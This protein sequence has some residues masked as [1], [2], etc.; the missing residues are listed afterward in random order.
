MELPHDK[1]WAYLLLTPPPLRDYFIQLPKP[2]TLQLALNRFAAYLEKQYLRDS[3]YMEKI[4]IGTHYNVRKNRVLQPRI[5][6][7]PSNYTRILSTFYDHPDLIAEVLP[8]QHLSKSQLKRGGLTKNV[9]TSGLPEMNNE[10]NPYAVFEVN[11]I[12]D[13][14]ACF[15]FPTE[16]LIDILTGRN[17]ISLHYTIDRTSIPKW[18]AHLEA[19]FQ[20]SDGVTKSLTDADLRQHYIGVQPIPVTCEELLQKMNDA[21]INGNTMYRVHGYESIVSSRM[22]TVNDLVKASGKPYDVVNVQTMSSYSRSISK[23]INQAVTK[24]RH[25]KHVGSTKLKNSQGPRTTIFVM[26]PYITVDVVCSPMTIKPGL[27]PIQTKLLKSIVDQSPRRFR[28][29]YAAKPQIEQDVL[30]KRIFSTDEGPESYFQGVELLTPEA[31]S[32]LTA[33]PQLVG[34]FHYEKLSYAH[35]P[36]YRLTAGGYN[37]DYFKRGVTVIVARKHGGKGMVAKLI[38]KLGTPVIDS[39][40]YGRIIKLVEAGLTIDDAVTQLFSMDYDQRNSTV[41][42]FDEHME[43]IVSQSKMKQEITYPRA[44]DPRITAFA[45]YYSKWFLKVPYSDYVASVKNFV[46]KNGLS[47]PNGIQSTN[48][49]DTLVIQVHTLPEATQFLGVNNII[50][51]YPIIDSYIGMILRQQ[52]SNTC[53]ELLLARYYESIHLRNFDMLPVGVVASTLEALVG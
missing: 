24:D 19:R 46:T 37:V 42:A 22:E 48:H 4:V 15:A 14:K 53:A 28:I 30:N 35:F 21:S 3:L 7:S 23:A 50:E 51:V 34:T 25:N 29:A 27:G 32:L 38:W 49:Y 45:D 52:T 8:I 13:L 43:M 12:D 26:P 20:Y 47:G 9:L 31:K 6:V 39:D 5:F 11:T 16:W 41:S 1:A 44:S 33:L 2:A 10:Q 17:S 40:D 18:Y 36:S